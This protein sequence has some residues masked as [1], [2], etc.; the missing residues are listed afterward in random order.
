[1]F[2]LVRKWFGAMRF[3]VVAVSRQDLTMNNLVSVRFFLTAFK[4]KA[5][6]ILSR[7]L[8]AFIRQMK[9]REATM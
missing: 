2:P 8:A 4:F 7:V 3:G 1:M 6:S 9:S 5:T